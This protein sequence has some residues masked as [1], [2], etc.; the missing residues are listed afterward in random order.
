MFS[1][2]LPRGRGL[3]L[4]VA[5]LLSAVTIRAAEPAALHARGAARLWQ[6]AEFQLT[7]VA[8]EGANPFDPDQIALDAVITT[9]AGHSREFPLFW[10]QDYRQE[11]ADGQETLAA[12]GDG[13]WRLRWLPR[14]PGA[15]RYEVR[16]RR[17]AAAPVVVATGVITVAAAPPPDRF[18]VVE[19]GADRRYLRTTDGRPLRL[20]GIN[21]CWLGGRGTF[22]YED[23]FAQM[24]H[25]GQNVARLWLSPWWLSLEQRPDTLTHYRMDAAWQLDRLFALAEQN[26]IYLLPC[27]DYH[28][29]FQEDDAQWGG[30]TNQWSENP[31]NLANGGPCREP[32]D[33]FTNA[34]ARRAYTKRLRYLVARYGANPRLLAWEFYNE[35]DNVFEPRSLREPD[36]LAWHQEMARWLKAHDPFGHLVTTSLT[37]GSDRPGFWQLPEIDV[38]MYHSYEE[39]APARRLAWIGRDFAARYDKPVIIGEYGVSSAGW[40]LPRDP[41]LRGLRQ[42]L[43]GAALGGTAGTALPWWWQELRDAGGTR[44][45]AALDAVLTRAGWAEGAWWPVGP[46]PAAPAAPVLGEPLPAVPAFA[47]ELIL[48]IDHRR[49]LSGRLALSGP[50]AAARAFESLSA[51]VLGTGWGD[52]RQSLTFEGWWDEDAAVRFH[53]HLAEGSPDLAVMIDGREVA[54]LPLEAPAGA[55]RGQRPIDRELAVTIPAGRHEISLVNHG[56]LWA[57]VDRCEVRGLRPTDAGEW[58]GPET[59]ALRGPDRAILYTVSPWMVYPAGATAATGPVVPGRAYDLMEWPAGDFQVTWYDPATGSALHSTRATTRDG[60]LTVRP[61]NFTE[62][63]VAV[64]LPD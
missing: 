26:G 19:L 16:L 9:P 4:A 27:L 61:P 62:D 8:A 38:A 59:I 30:M 43:W 2:H 32:N 10:F 22:D 45:Y 20:V 42:A 52:K 49:P 37:G 44:L 23:W 7:G 63:I 17:G 36:V 31:Y 15:H 6:P 55:A 25:S 51:Y 46:A 57:R 40:D 39:I 24:R 60:V 56:T 35:I 11:L 18:G 33:F 5:C 14:E 29:M 58:T 48:N 47:G 64:V 34:E 28:G 12:Q 21:L 41:H 50:L 3:I 53:F 54:R 13:E 1:G